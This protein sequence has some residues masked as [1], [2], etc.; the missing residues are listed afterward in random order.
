MSKE[1]KVIDHTGSSFDSFLEEED[2][3]KESE[4]V[5]L[6]RVI[7]WQLKTAMNKKRVTKSWM[8][9]ELRTS[10]S[11]VDRLLDPL[12][13]GVSIGTVAKAARAVG[14]AFRMEFVEEDECRKT[15][16]PKTHRAAVGA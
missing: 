16:R 11:Q 2:L 14:K 13:V 4:A 8:A 6:K 5:A 12:N 1:S 10:R 7:A 9:H 15:K 3:L